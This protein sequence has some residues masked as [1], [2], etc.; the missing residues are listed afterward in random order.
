MRL[1][2]IF[3]GETDWVVAP[4]A[5]AARRCYVLDYGLSE[6]DMDGVDITLV[7]DP[8]SVVVDTDEVDAETGETRTTT[9]AEVMAGMTRP[10]IIAST[11]Q[12]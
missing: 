11:W 2:E 1:Y 8:S 3:S 10:G 4:D 12:R 5:A 6:C 7:A 9:A